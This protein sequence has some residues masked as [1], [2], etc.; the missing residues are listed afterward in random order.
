MTVSAPTSQRCLS[1]QNV[2]YTLNIP[3]AT[4]SSGKGDI[5]FQISAPTSYSWVALGQGT[6]MAGANIFVIYSSADGKNVTLSPRT[7]TGHVQPQY[8]SAAQVT[9]LAGSGIFDG[10]MIANVRCSNCDSWADNGSMDFTSTSASWIYAMTSGGM[11]NSDDVNAGI[12]QHAFSAAASFTWDMSAAKGGD[13]ANPFVASSA[14][15]TAGTA[16]TTGTTPGAATTTDSNTASAATGSSSPTSNGSNGSGSSNAN[17]NNGAETAEIS[18]SDSAPLSPLDRAALAH[19]ALAGLAFLAFFPAGGIL[20]RLANF[21]AVVRVHA[22]LQLF[23]FA[24]FIAAAG[25]GVWMLC[26]EEFEPHGHPYLGGVVFLLV[27][28]QPVTGWFHHR[29]YAAAAAAGAAPVARTKTTKTHIGLGRAAILLGILN[30][31]F[32]L[33]MAD[34]DGGPAIAYGVLAGLVAVGYIASIFIGEK[35]RRRRVTEPGVVDDERS[36]GDS[37]IEVEVPKRG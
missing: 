21:P 28:A 32:G 8:N 33:H 13:D 36:Q 4:A 37:R 3:D 6:G 24:T 2:C 9:L 23:A 22:V 15:T 34:I 17:T 16:T 12:R 31:G 11:L 10:T 14:A 35:R 27:L 18:A 25:L 29:R 26:A 30:G 5:F 7:G 20:I 1:A 19:G